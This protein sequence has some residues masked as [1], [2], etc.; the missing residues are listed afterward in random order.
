ML[1]NLSEKD[2]E[3]LFYLKKYAENDVY[4][5]EDMYALMKGDGVAPGDQPEFVR[6]IFDDTCRVVLTHEWQP[7]GT[8]RHASISFIKG[9]G[10]ANEQTISKILLCLGFVDGKVDA[11]IE[12]KTIFNAIQLL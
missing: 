12:E 6:Y 3:S 1:I 5:K 4:D 10:I 9:T 2:I 7:I 8:C 11:Y